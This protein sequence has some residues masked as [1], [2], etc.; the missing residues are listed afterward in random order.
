MPT[1]DLPE[2]KTL[3]A[4]RPLRQRAS[5]VWLVPVTALA[6]ALGLALQTYL[7]RG[8]LIEII[9]DEASGVAA[10]STE[11]RFRDVTVGKVEAL[12]FEPGLEKVAVHV[13]LDK[14]IAPYVDE[15]AVFWVVKPEVTTTGVSGLDTVLS[16]VFIAGVWD[17][18]PGETKLRHE[19]QPKAPL[20]PPGRDGLLLTLQAANGVA[21]T[22]NSPITYKGLEVGMVGTPEL[23]RDRLSAIA[24][25]VI[26]A[27]YDRLVQSTTRFWDTSGFSFSIGAGGAEL[28]FSSL[29]SLIAGGISFDTVI[30]GGVGVRDR[31]A[32]QVF[33]SQSEARQNVFDAG[34][35]TGVPFTVIF[36]EN[37]SGLEAGAPVEVRGLRIG[38]VT[39]ITGIVDPLRFG[40]GRV[41]LQVSLELRPGE[42]GLTPVDDPTREVEDF[43][44]QRVE[45]GMRARLVSTGLLST[46][47]KL[48]LV[49]LETVDRATLDRANS[50]YPLIPTTESQISD[51]SASAQ[52]MLTRVADL[53]IE[54]LMQSAVRFLDNASGLAAQ[55]SS[56]VQDGEV[57]AIP[58]DVRALLGDMRGV[59]GAPEVQGL[60]A[61][62]A[63]LMEEL[64]GTVS[65]L[66]GLVAQ[67][68]EARAVEKLVN[69]VEAAGSAA[70]AAEA[71]ITG[72]PGLIDSLTATA[73]TARALPLEELVNRVSAIVADAETLLEQPGTRALPE[74]LN[75]AL[76]EVRLSL[77]ELREGGS[78]T[79]LNET[80]A[81]AQSA[82]AAIEQATTE[83]PQISDRIQRLLSQASSTLAGYDQGSEINRSA[84]AAMTALS[85]AA[86]A[87]ESLARALERRP[88]S[89]ILGR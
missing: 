16:G 58:G 64:N 5:L 39:G 60:P 72:V 12:E 74:T 84:R 4:R 14:A 19:G 24:P 43:I 70:E 63:T 52:G 77:T 34:R 35:G 15:D 40:D 62:A 45:E 28:D 1:D 21:L 18:E 57:R 51:A 27:P 59:V 50:P 86:S 75:G 61:Q 79:A 66:R 9:F 46:G 55:T 47:L 42:L 71:S 56:L 81:S 30:S 17:T 20:L 85:R 88:N 25:A 82:A 49:D 37:V 3:P 2:A 38:E 22:A 33:A 32:F 13:R 76:E 73:D 31:A 68:E 10:G 11:L 54:E 89:I 8:P 26:Y 65:D 6:I 80:L 36:E 29:S 48:E 83:L 53:P 69:A 44:A 67:V 23:S 87:V 78:V 7:A 41:R